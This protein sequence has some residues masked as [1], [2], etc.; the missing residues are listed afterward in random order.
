MFFNVPQHTYSWNSI[1]F[2][3]IFSYV[4]RPPFL[5]NSSVV[6]LQFQANRQT[7][8]RFEAA[9]AFHDGEYSFRNT[10]GKTCLVYF[11][12]VLF[13]NAIFL[14]INLA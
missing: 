9:F 1:L 3:F 2:E 14:K 10:L 7:V 8:D 5:V 12:F 11:V 4:S 6:F 13:Q